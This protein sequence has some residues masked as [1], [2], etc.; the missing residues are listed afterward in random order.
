MQGTTADP[1]AARCGRRG[2]LKAAGGTAV[3]IGAIGATAG[4]ASAQE[5]GAAGWF[6][7]VSNF[8]KVVDKTGTKQT[9]VAVGAKG[10]GGN[11]AFSPPAIRV[12]PGTTITW[13][14]TGE[15]GGHNVVAES[16]AFESEIASEAGHTFEHTFEEKGAVNY[17]CVP[18][19]SMGMRGAVLVGA[20][21]AVGSGAE[22]GS[23]E[24]SSPYGGWLD[25]VDGFEEVVDGTGRDRVEIGV[26]APGNGGIFA[27]D[28]PAIHIDPGTTIVWRRLEES[29]ALTVVADDESFWTDFSGTDGETFEWTFT[30]NRVVKYSCPAYEELGMKGLLV[31][32]NPDLPSAGDVLSTPWGGALAGSGLM[33][34]L[35]PLVFGGFLAVRRSRDREP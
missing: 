17:A 8:E 16:G 35:S 1:S 2:F 28:P 6:D 3:G 4:T 7:G 27:F 29:E 26:G 24:S 5:G 23:E 33:A 19:R 21:A 14:W 13:K 11:F 12:D 20:D 10:N 31:V 22:N 15:G 25:D 30:G 9:E 18:H 32:G 34:V